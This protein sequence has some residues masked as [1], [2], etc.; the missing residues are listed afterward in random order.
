MDKA[1]SR[2]G[3]KKLKSRNWKPTKNII[4]QSH[5]KFWANSPG[6]KSNLNQ[7]SVKF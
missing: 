1:N 3:L 5:A 7:W 4:T 6:L 2:N